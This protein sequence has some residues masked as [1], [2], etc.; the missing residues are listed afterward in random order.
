VDKR[1]QNA[2]LVEELYGEKKKTQGKYF[3]LL[4]DV[5]KFSEETHK[6]VME[7][8]YARIMSEG[9]RSKETEQL[10]KQIAKLKQI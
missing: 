8:N 6:M 9:E 2:K 1:I 7:K 3:S 5:R 10:H 4:D